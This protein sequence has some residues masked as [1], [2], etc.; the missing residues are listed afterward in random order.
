MNRVGSETLEDG[1]RLKKAEEVIGKPIFWQIP[2][3]AKAVIGSRVAGQPL[4]NSPRNRVS[5]RAS[6]GSSRR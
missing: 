6:S 3:D 5:S 1:I 2:N 4:V